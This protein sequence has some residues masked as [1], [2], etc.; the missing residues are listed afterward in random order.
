[1]EFVGAVESLDQVVW[2][3]KRKKNYCKAHARKF[4]FLKIEKAFTQNFTFEMKHTISV[5]ARIVSYKKNKYIRNGR[6]EPCLIVFH[7]VRAL[8]R[9]KEGK[10]RSWLSLDSSNF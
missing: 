10:E 8:G 2:R 7:S 4:K 5:Y 9:R 3:K 6:F 1:M